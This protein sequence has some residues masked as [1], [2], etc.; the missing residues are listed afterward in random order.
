MKA[1][2]NQETNKMFITG[3][4]LPWSVNREV[5]IAW[6]LC[7]NE[8]LREFEEDK[9]ILFEN[10][11]VTCWVE[12]YPLQVHFEVRGLAR[13]DNRLPIPKKSLGL[14][15]NAWREFIS[16]LPPGIEFIGYYLEDDGQADKRVRLF[17][18]LGFEKLDEDTLVFKT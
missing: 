11:Q 16:K 12:L 13:E 3:Q 17:K 2:F 7:L 5:G 15:L 6:E 8:N 14:A 9:F 1:Y 4:D 18:R 10:S